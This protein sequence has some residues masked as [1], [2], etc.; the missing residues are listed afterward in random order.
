MEYHGKFG[1][2]IGR[3]QRIDIMIIIDIYQENCHLATQTVAPTIP[4]YQ[5]IK[6]CA[7][8]LD[9]HPHKTIFHPSNYYD[10]SIE[11]RLTWS[12]DKVEDYT[13]Q[14]VLEFHQYDDNVRTLNRRWE[15]S[16]ILNT[17]LSVYVCWKV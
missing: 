12:G 6:P 16:D 10:G 13:T 17:L 3:I 1:H 14:N 5:G 7:Q 2:N 9:S 11:I 15:V 4:G 8:F